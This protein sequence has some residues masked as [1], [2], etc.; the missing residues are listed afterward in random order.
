M[1]TAADD[2]LDAGDANAHR[3]ALLALRRRRMGDRECLDPAADAQRNLLGV[4]A[5][6]V[7][8]HDGEFLAAIPGGDVERPARC[9]TQAPCHLAQTL[10]ASLVAVA[11]VVGLEVI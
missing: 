1:C 8:E 9:A 2:R 11:V 6:R 3:Q 4:T 5:T 7:I 10:V